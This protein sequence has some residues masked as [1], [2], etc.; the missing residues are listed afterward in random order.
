MLCIK[1]FCGNS[2]VSIP[3]IKPLCF[4]LYIFIEYIDYLLNIY[5]SYNYFSKGISHPVFCGDLVYKLRKVKDTTNFISSG[6]KIVQRLRRWQNDPLIIE[7]T[8]G[9]V[10]GPSTAFYI[11]FLKHSA[12]TNKAVGT[13]WRALAKP[14]QRRQGPDLRPSDC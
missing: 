14:R 3:D 8:K 7:R 9:L 5:K 1:Y 11:P 12:L 10:L 4:H 2:V 13:I 6:S